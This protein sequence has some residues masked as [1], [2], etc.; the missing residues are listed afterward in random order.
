MTPDNETFI[1]SLRVPALEKV[2]PI[3]FGSILPKVTADV[4]QP[5]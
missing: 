4:E 2:M 5:I 3:L 1:L